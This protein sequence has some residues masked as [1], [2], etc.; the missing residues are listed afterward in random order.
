[1]LTSTETI[2]LIRDGRGG[3]KGGGGGVY[4]PVATLLTRMTPAE[5]GGEGREGGRERDRDRET[6]RERD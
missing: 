6:E 2:R 1:M 3:G 4:M 5:R